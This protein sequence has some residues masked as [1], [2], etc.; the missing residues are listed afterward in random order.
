MHRGSW[1]K[2]SQPDSREMEQVKLDTEVIGGLE[3]I[4][5]K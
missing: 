5:F 3:P 4:S 1:S 2:S